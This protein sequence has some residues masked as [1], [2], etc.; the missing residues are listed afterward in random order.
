MKTR[1]ENSNHIKHSSS[2]RSF[3]ATLLSSLSLG[4]VFIS[5]QLKSA[6]GIPKRTLG[7]TGEKVSIIGLG[8]WDV[9]S[10]ESE[11]EV[12]SMIQEAADSG[13]TFFDNSWDYLDGKAETLMGKALSENSRREKIF[14]MT[15]VCGRTYDNARK[16]LEDSL[17]RL[18]TDRLD[19][20]QFHGIKRDT[21]IDQIF[22]PENGALKAAIEAKKEGKVRFIGFTGHHHPKYHKRMLEQ[23]F[24]WDTVQMPINMLDAHY[25]SFQKEIMPICNDRN[26]GVIGMKSLGAQDARIASELNLDT[27]V[28]RRFSMSLPIST[29]VIGIQNRAE[30]R[31]DLEIAQNFKPLTEIELKE[32]IDLAYEKGSAGEVEAYKLGSY[33]CDWEL[34][35]G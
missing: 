20:W 4:S 8:G 24:D 15:K 19:L 14:L 17:R 29:L 28:C 25:L 10:K 5:G 6:T 33:G 26:I 34:N 16:H 12:I 7:K 13:V 35:N 1:Q 23:D 31:K 27:S 21:D 11:K 2:R 32:T 3:L 9:A 18:K 30:L 22:D